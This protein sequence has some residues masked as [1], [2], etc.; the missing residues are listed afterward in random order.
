MDTEMME[1]F[2]TKWTASLLLLH[3]WVI[4]TNCKHITHKDHTHTHTHTHKRNI[5]NS[6]VISNFVLL[7]AVI[8]FKQKNKIS[9]A[10]QQD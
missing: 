2:T 10:W 6:N 5:I 8:A 3:G 1:I 7:T 4:L 9:M